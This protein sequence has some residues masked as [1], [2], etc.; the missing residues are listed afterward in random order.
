MEENDL[1]TSIEFKS[2][3]D[4]LL[5]TS[6]KAFKDFELTELFDS[7]LQDLSKIQ[8][9]IETLFHNNESQI[10]MERDSSSRKPFVKE[11]ERSD[12]N[13]LSMDVEAN[14]NAALN[15]LDIESLE[16]ILKSSYPNKKFNLNK[17]IEENSV[18]LNHALLLLKSYDECRESEEAAVNETYLN[19]I[20]KILDGI[21]SPERKSPAK[22]KKDPAIFIE[23]NGKEESLIK[24]EDNGINENDLEDFSQF[25]EENP[26][27]SENKELFPKCEEMKISTG[28][29][30][31]ARKTKNCGIF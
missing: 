26:A 16:Q 2:Q 5:N 19:E 14:P 12:L 17:S 15:N 20:E 25:P 4:H 3:L 23:Q 11:K 9:N 24:A 22:A 1:Q 6:K 31:R 8:D 18:A 27:S 28:F 29:E 10:L 21:Q 7:K 30:E 13:L